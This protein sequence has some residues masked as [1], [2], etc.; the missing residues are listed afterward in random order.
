MFLEATKTRPWFH[1][2]CNIPG[3]NSGLNLWFW[4]LLSAPDPR[5]RNHK[6]AIFLTQIGI[7]RL[8]TNISFRQDFL[9]GLENCAL[10]NSNLGVATTCPHVLLEADPDEL[11]CL[12][13]K[14]NEVFKLVTCN[15]TFVR[16][17]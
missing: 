14:I 11:L 2:F 1:L 12:V 7:H 16:I 3:L 4:W 8:P 9:L 10:N 15:F 5:S 6:A 13:D 17:Q